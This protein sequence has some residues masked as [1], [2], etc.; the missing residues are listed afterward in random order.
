M[1]VMPELVEQRENGYYAVRYE[2]LTPLLIEA[3]KTQSYW[4]EDQK[5]MILEK[6][7]TIE[8]VSNRLDVLEKLMKDILG[9]N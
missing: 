4:I 7:K 9:K 8:D 5:Q 2:K 6:N 3:V 1:K